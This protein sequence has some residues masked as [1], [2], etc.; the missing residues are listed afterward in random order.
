MYE[1]KLLLYVVHH[2]ANVEV[3]KY[4]HTLCDLSYLPGC[5]AS[6]SKRVLARSMKMNLQ[7]KRIFLHYNSLA[8]RL[9]L[10]QKWPQIK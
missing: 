5:H 8:R 6:V 10:T 3:R 9:V 4:N 1:E 7:M 2:I